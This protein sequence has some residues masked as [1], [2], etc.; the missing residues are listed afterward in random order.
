M[1]NWIHEFELKHD[2]PL[3]DVIVSVLFV[4][5]AVVATMQIPYLMISIKKNGAPISACFIL[6]FSFVFSVCFFFF[7]L[8]FFFETFEA[9][10]QYHDQFETTCM[11]EVV[12]M[13]SIRLR[14]CLY[15][16]RK[17]FLRNGKRS[18]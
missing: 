12:R 1:Q 8:N 9:C 4:L 7:N 15:Y 16:H 6:L 5:S 17:A 11:E 2:F 14:L 18:S 3:D 10:V 13:C